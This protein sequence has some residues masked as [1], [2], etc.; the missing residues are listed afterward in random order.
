MAKLKNKTDKRMK[1]TRER[2][3][4]IHQKSIKYL[5]STV[6]HTHTHTATGQTQTRSGVC[7]KR[8]NFFDLT[9]KNDENIIYIGR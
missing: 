1:E 4:K 8:N 7:G 9:N 5:R 2:E 6:R 3:K